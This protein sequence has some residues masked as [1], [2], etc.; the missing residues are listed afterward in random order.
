[1]TLSTTGTSRGRLRA[2]SLLARVSPTPG[3]VPERRF[4]P[5]DGRQMCV[6]GRPQVQVGGHVSK[7]LIELGAAGVQQF[8]QRTRLHRDVE[9]RDGEHVSG[10]EPVRR[11]VG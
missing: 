11:I 10:R 5:V 4:E 9:E 3:R 8:L 7:Q 2:I 6:G 1:M